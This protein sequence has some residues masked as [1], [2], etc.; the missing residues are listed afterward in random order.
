MRQ[1]C[2]GLHILAG[3]R[4]PILDIIGAL[5]E[6]DPIALPVDNLDGT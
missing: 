2:D 5:A 1:R 6:A 3:C 4:T